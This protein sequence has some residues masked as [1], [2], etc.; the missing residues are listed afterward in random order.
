LGGCGDDSFIHIQFSPFL[1]IHINKK[2]F[3]LEC[4]LNKNKILCF[5]VC[6]MLL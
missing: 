6:C 1:K 2:R 4:I 3:V 5:V